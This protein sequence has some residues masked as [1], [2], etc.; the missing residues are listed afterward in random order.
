[1][2]ICLQCRRPR[3]HLIPPLPSSPDT[4][5][6][7]SIAECLGH[8][9]SFLL[10]P[11]PWLTWNVLTLNP[12]CEIPLILYILDTVTKKIL[13][14]LS[15]PFHTL[16]K[17]ITGPSDFP[18]PFD[19]HCLH[20]NSDHSH[21]FLLLYFKP[22][23]LN[24]VT[25]PHSQREGHQDPSGKCLGDTSLPSCPLMPRCELTLPTVCFLRNSR[26]IVSALIAARPSC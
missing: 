25:F 17:F 7:L 23:S 10:S 18:P 5:I 20:I 14:R 26:Y 19:F 22:F 4:Y 2:I 16:F 1:M 13:V 3:F 12:A 15:N 9:F 24:H 11:F 8:A 6:Q 21:H